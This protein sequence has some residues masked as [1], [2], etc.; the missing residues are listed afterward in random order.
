MSLRLSSFFHVSARVFEFP[1]DRASRSFVSQVSFFSVFFM[2]VFIL[3]FEVVFF[4]LEH[5]G[6]AKKSPPWPP[7]GRQD[8]TKIVPKWSSRRLQWP[9]WKSSNSFCFTTLLC[10]R[11]GPKTGINRVQGGFVHFVMYVDFHSVFEPLLDLPK[12]N[13]VGNMSPPR[14]SKRS[15]RSGQNEVKNWW[16]IMLLINSNLQK[17]SVFTGVCG[18]PLLGKMRNQIFLFVF[19]FESQKWPSWTDFHALGRFRAICWRC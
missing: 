10:P 16:K 7:L 4:A 18:P 8:G 1:L 5:V 11:E 6:C 9:K 13:L 3:L 19:F 14:D 15:L 2:F 12:S 17:P